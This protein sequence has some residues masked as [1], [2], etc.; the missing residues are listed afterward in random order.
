[1]SRAPK[2]PASPCVPEGVCAALAGAHRGWA[3]GRNA[4]MAFSVWRSS[5]VLDLVRSFLFQEALWIAGPNP[6][7]PSDSTLSVSFLPRLPLAE[8]FCVSG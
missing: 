5:S 8:G 4:L 6:L 1:M 2:P 3:C 7:S